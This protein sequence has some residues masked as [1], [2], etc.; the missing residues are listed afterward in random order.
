MKEELEEN[1]RKEKVLGSRL[2]NPQRKVKVLSLQKI[3][4]DQVLSLLAHLKLFDLHNHLDLVRPH[5]V[6][7]LEDKP[8][9]RDVH[10]VVSSILDLVVL[11]K[12]VSSV[13]RQV[14]LRGFALCLILLL[15]WDKP[16]ISQEL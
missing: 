1:F 5:Q 12:C 15:Q 6:L 10:D 11:R 7:F 2:G 3:H 14:M 9:Q 16:W 8:H 4:L 13:G